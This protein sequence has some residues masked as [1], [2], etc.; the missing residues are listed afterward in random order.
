MQIVIDIEVLDFVCLCGIY[1]FHSVE[2]YFLNRTLSYEASCNV[3]DNLFVIDTNG[4]QHQIPN[5]IRNIITDFAFE[6][7]LK[8]MT[9]E[10]IVSRSCKNR[11]V[12]KC[13]CEYLFDRKMKT[14]KTEDKVEKTNSMESR[15][16]IINCIYPCAFTQ[17][18]SW[19]RLWGDR[20][21]RMHVKKQTP[22]DFLIDPKIHTVRIKQY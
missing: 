9:C 21:V 8:E 14:C 6:S 16:F 10:K 12:S 2:N 15:S 19:H 7:R 11:K 20:Q 5:H 3:L 22:C 1:I 18:W 4:Q 17:I 13:I